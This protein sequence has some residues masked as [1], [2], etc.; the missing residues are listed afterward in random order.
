MPAPQATHPG[1]ATPKR[2]LQREQRVARTEC[3]VEK[4]VQRRPRER[5]TFA[6]ALN[7]DQRSG[8]GGDYVHVDLGARIFL[9]RKIDAHPTVDDPTLT[10][11][12]AHDSGRGSDLPAAARVGHRVGERHIRT[13]DRRRPRAP[14]VCSTS[15][16]I[17]MVFAERGQIYACAGNA[18]R[19]G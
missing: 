11:A 13:C 17:A 1:R 16:S 3:G 12:M 2:P 19:V 14:S 10:A 9:V 7:F 6:C 8:V 18:R 15:Q 4:F 5:R